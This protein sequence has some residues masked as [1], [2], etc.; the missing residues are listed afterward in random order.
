MNKPFSVTALFINGPLIL[1]VS[2][3]NNPADFG[4][5]GGKIDPGETPEEALCRE[6]LEETGLVVGGYRVAFEDPDRVE[7]GEPRPCRSYL[8]LSWNGELYTK[9][10]GV[11]KW[12][13]PSVV[14][15]PATSFHEYNIRLFSHLEKSGI[16]RLTTLGK[17]RLVSH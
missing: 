7:G 17:Y 13:E 1:A 8:I 9:E 2:R 4:L 12:V 5:P 15:D 10:T 3:K 16:F 14:T 11:V 6:V